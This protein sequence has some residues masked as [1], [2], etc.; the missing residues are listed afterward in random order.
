MQSRAALVA[1]AVLAAFVPLPPGSVDR[2]Y[3]ARV[4]AT[5]QPLL[6]SISNLA[7]FAVLDA[8]LGIMAAAWLAL[9]V[10]DLVRKPGGLRGVRRVAARTVTWCAVLYLLFLAS[11]GLNYRRPRMRDSRT[12]D[13][14]AVT[15]EAARAAG[16]RAVER[17]NALHDAAHAASRPFP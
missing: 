16:A 6:T 3:T 5:L 15:A 2:L 14:T 1:A 4:Y 8:V 9:A 7:P 11:W 12:F 10:R 13:A 17:L